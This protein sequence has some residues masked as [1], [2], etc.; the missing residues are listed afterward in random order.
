MLLYSL[1]Y[2]A[3]PNP[4]AYI[5]MYKEK[6]GLANFTIFQ[7]ENQLAIQL[8]P[9]IAFYISFYDDLLFQVKE[10]PL[11]PC[12]SYEV[13]A[14]NNQ[15]LYFEEIDEKTGKSPGFTFPGLFGLDTFSRY[16]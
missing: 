1:Q 13:T 8:S 15:W 10:P 3:P 7:Y 6:L 14:A 11:V 9:T 16:E 4:E 5:G 12:I 2:P